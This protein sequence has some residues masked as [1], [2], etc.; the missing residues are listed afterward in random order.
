[1]KN[2][3]ITALFA[4]AV[5]TLVGV[6]MILALAQPVAAQPAQRRFEIQHSQ[7]L[8]LVGALYVIRDIQANECFFLVLNHDGGVAEP[9]EIRCKR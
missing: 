4:A 1:M 2:L 6:A 9:R 3:V 5:G 8:D 7:E